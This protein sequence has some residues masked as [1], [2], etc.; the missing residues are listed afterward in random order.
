VLSWW[1]K[2]YAFA[3][4]WQIQSF[5]GPRDGERFRTGTGRPVLMLPGIWETWGFLRPLIEPLHAAGHPVHVLPA[6]RRNGRPVADTA[7]LVAG[8]LEDHDLRDVVI[9]AH[10]KGGLIGKYLMT[11]LDPEQRIHRMVALATP[12]AGSIYA[13]FML[14]PSLR[15]FSPTDPTTLHLQ[16]IVDVNARIIS[17]SGVFDPHIPGLW[18]LEGGTNHTIDT[19][20]HFRVIGQPETIRL[21]VEAA[22]T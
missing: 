17:I 20:G 5:L 18:E 14:A 19:G 8:Y 4:H 3:A 21:V 13:R 6:L 2:D 9:V 7:R 22:A 16:K 11:E 1:V 12:F 15:S 10:S